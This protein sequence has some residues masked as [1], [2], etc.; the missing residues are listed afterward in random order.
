MTYSEP[1][2]SQ[3]NYFFLSLGF[4]MI[5]DVWYVLIMMLRM[6]ISEKKWAYVLFDIFFSLTVS[7]ASFFFMV[8][9]N[10]GLVRLNLILGQLAGAT[11]LHMIMGRKVINLFK[12]PAKAVRQLL[13][14]LLI[15]TKSF[16]MIFTLGF[17]KVKDKLVHCSNKKNNKNQKKFNI[18]TKMHLKNKNKSV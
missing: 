18:I 17:S 2:L 13:V 8:I 12:K 4:G 3:F 9:Y 1:L 6:C 5:L 16:F 7:V 14:F 10:N 11:A 15:P